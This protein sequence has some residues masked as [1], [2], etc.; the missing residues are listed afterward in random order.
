MP[1]L[2]STYTFRRITG[3]LVLLLVMTVWV[4]P[5]PAATTPASSIGVRLSATTVFET[6]VTARSLVHLPRPTAITP[7][8]FSFEVRGKGLVG[9]VILAA[10][11]ATGAPARTGPVLVALSIG[12]CGRPRCTAGA[13]G[14]L[15]FAAHLRGSVLPAGNYAAYMVTDREDASVT[16]NLDSLQ[17]GRTLISGGELVK[18]GL[19]S[20]KTVVPSQPASAYS[21]STVTGARG[22]GISISSIWSGDSTPGVAAQGHCMYK[23]VPAVGVAFCPESDSGSSVRIIAGAT[24]TI[25]TLVQTGQIPGAV[26]AWAANPTRQRDVEALSFW[27]KF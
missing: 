13:R 4:A 17:P 7:S 12:P 23:D 25:D 6:G 5:S 11:D 20:A 21:A 3:L 1:Q 16:L 8:S 18:H 14:D 26:G 27:L 9:G 24:E 10:T 15:L 2:M 22:R 19:S